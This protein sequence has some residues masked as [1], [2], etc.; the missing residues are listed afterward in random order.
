MSVAARLLLALGASALVA[1]WLGSLYRRHLPDAP[2][3]LAWG[4]A[5]MTGLA[6]YFWPG[7]GILALAGLAAIEVGLARRGG[8]RPFEPAVIRFEG[9]GI[10]RG[11]T[12]A[13]A[14]V[15]LGRPP[16]VILAL[17]LTEML[18]KRLLRL[19]KGAALQMEPAEAMRTRQRS[20]NPERRGALRRK[21]AQELGK[22][23]HPFEEPILELLEQRPDSPAGA[24]DFGLVMMPLVEHVAR[25][26]GGHD[27][28]ETREYYRLLIA[29]APV[30]ARS[31]GVLQKDREKIFTRNLGWILLDEAFA[32]ILDQADFRFRPDWLAEAQLPGEPSL[33]EWTA[34]LREALK[35]SVG[36]EDLAAR[37]GKGLDG[38]SATL[39]SEIARATYYG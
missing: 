34:G 36:T 4:L 15:L 16:N 18:H 28:A 35:G 25:R 9:G 10:K 20:L 2:R 13:E 29:R 22:T 11:L 24:L 1:L 31:E 6:S 17:A 12:A 21:G 37:L 33:A 14:A 26:V 7:L 8:S 30:E 27:L 5:G 19:R 38:V 3:R 32:D 23:L 39:M